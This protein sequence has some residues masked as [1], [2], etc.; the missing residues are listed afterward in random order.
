LSSP[1]RILLA[2][3]NPGDAFLVQ[4]ALSSR[5]LNYTLRTA[6]DG[7][8]ALKL[9]EDAEAGQST[10]DLLLLDLN[11]PKVPGERILERVRQSE[12]LKP[13][14]VIVVTSSDSPKDR[15]RV[16]A[17]G[18]NRYFRKPSDLRAFLTLGGVVEEVYASSQQKHD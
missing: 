18:A 6:A 17:L 13:L 15:A 5:K 2:E 12:H 1:I 4:Q 3:D 14:P 8:L 9:L 10:F 11:L 7:E 16:A